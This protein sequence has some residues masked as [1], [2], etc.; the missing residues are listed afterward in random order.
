MLEKKKIFWRLGIGKQIL[1]QISIY[2]DSYQKL[3]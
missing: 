2:M 3:T 1:Y